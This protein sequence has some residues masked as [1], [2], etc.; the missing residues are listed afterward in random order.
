LVGKTLELSFINLAA[1]K[2][3]VNINNMLGQKVQEVAISH[4]G[5]NA[6][7]A[8]TVNNTMLA[9]TYIVTILNAS[10][11]KIYQSKLSFQP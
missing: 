7:H 6:K 10:G 5:G 3:T 4:A 1:G 11:Y 9:G 8:I 2:Y